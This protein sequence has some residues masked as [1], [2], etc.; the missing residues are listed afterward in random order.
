MA[1]KVPCVRHGVVGTNDSSL[2]Q[3]LRTAAPR[4]SLEL[5]MDLSLAVSSVTRY[6]DSVWVIWTDDASRARC[7]AIL[8]E[9]WRALGA[10]S[11]VL[12]LIPCDEPYDYEEDVMQ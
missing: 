6:D 2:V 12:H 9:T 3:L 1:T 4:V 10:T 11:T 8:D 5:G 7:S